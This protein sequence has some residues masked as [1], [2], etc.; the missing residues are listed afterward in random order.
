MTPEAGGV[1][2]ASEMMPE[3]NREHC[4]RAADA[5]G[6]GLSKAA[7]RG[8]MLLRRSALP[9][10]EI[11][12]RS[13][14]IAG[15]V[16]SLAAWRQAANVLAYCAVR[17]EAD[18]APLVRAAWAAGKRVYLPRV[19]GKEMIFLPYLPDMPLVRSRFGIPEP[20]L[21][22]GVTAGAAAPDSDEK[23]MSLTMECCGISEPADGKMW[24]EGTGG[25]LRDAEACGASYPAG[26]KMWPQGTGGCLR[27]AG[28]RGASYPAEADTLVIVP[29][30]AFSRNGRRIGYGGGYYDRF[31]ADPDRRGRCILVGIGYDFQILDELPAE[32]HDVRLDYLAGEVGV[33]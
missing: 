6:A 27:D 14:K 15:E 26:G 21:P 19:M 16:M 29:G 17:G 12:A 1:P 2:G 22:E 28:G 8:E 25:C 11:A 5:S 18:P 23:T 3:A 4:R 9:E 20:A 10:D 7:L 24:P 32:A 30:A 13:E 31:F 33:W